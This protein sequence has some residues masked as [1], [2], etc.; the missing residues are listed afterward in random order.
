MSN[1]LAANSDHSLDISEHFDDHYEQFGQLKGTFQLEREKERELF[2]FGAK[3]KSFVVQPNM[4]S[5]HEATR[6]IIFAKVSL[7]KC[8]MFCTF[9]DKFEATRVM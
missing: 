5:S 7:P 2:L 3:H 6:V 8:S 1:E 9:A 4:N